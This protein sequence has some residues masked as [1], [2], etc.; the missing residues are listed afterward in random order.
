[1]AKTTDLLKQELENT[2]TLSAYATNAMRP[3]II[4]RAL[5]GKKRAI[6]KKMAE[7]AGVAEE[8]L[9][10]WIYNVQSLYDSCVAFHEAIGTDSEKEAEQLAWDVWKTILKAGEK[11]A[12]TP[13]LLVR[14]KDVET[15]RV[16]ACEIEHVLVQGVAPVAVY[17][18]VEKF[19][20]M[21][22]TRLAIRIA[23]NATLKD[24]DAEILK[25]YQKAVRMVA[26]AQEVIDGI[27]DG[28]NKVSSIGAQI[29][30]A[31]T[32]LKEMKESLEAAG[33]K[34]PERFTARAQAAL[35]SLKKTE[36][37]AKARLAKWSK[38]QKDL[39]AKYNEIEA[40]LDSIEG[41]QA[42][43]DIPET[44]ES[45]EEIEKRLKEILA[46]TAEKN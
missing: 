11:S 39:E 37:D 9:D 22:E 24:G 36:K 23:G 43:E 29:T 2:K 7:E 10:S 1:M 35:N 30:D 17:T 31:E 46:K 14:E 4:Q 19:R 3:A 5:D 33:V 28:K 26:R 12:L 16:Y 27:D 34:D 42:A 41:A 40:R 32:K 44:K 18:G 6:T 13:T 8:S 21:V 38:V 15:L 20:G 45:S 25:Q